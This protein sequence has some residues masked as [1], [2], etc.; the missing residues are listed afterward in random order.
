MF[1]NPLFQTSKIYDVSSL[2]ISLGTELG[3][4]AAGP[5]GPSGAV[6]PTGSAGPGI[7]K[8]TNTLGGTG[9]S[10]GTTIIQTTS[11]TLSSC[12]ILASFNIYNI[13]NNGAIYATIIKSTDNFNTWTNLVT[14]TQVE[15][16]SVSTSLFCASPLI[17]NPNSDQTTCTM[18]FFDTNSAAVQYGIRVNGTTTFTSSNIQLNILRLT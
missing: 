1:S 17:N 2:D 7:T 4:G 15:P 11:Q 10:P 12:I 3:I 9:T 8:Y 13:V 18:Q 16:T 14:G 6:G 5:S